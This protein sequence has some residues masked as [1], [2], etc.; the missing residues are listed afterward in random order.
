MSRWWIYLRERSPLPIY[1]FLC[2]GISASGVLVAGGGFAAR[3]FVVSCLGQILFFVLLR[4]T[5]EVKDYH[6][7]VV[8]H[9]ERPFPRGLIGRPEAERMIGALFLAMLGYGLFTGLLTNGPGG[10]LFVGLTCYLYL[11]HREFFVP[12]WLN[13]R[14]IW[15]A[16]THQAVFVPFSVLPAVTARAGMLEE[17]R[18]WLFGGCV[19]GAFFSYE[20]CRKLDPSAEPVLKTYLIVHGK[21]ITFCLVLAASCL[22]AYSAWSLGYG[23]LLWPL[24]GLLLASLAIIF[25]CPARYK[26]VETLAVL[27]FAAHVWSAVLFQLFGAI[28][29]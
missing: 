12:D 23:L 14:P 5:D 8:A 24:E 3:P 15:Y 6:K 20:V 4:L 7:D 9:P 25:C 28:H 10:W 21:V 22:A 13:E 1:L 17:P 2:A 18:A 26:I 11:M 19:L 16:I 27:S 29:G